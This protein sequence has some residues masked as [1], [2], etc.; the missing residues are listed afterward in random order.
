M[1]TA[2]TTELA[3]E[4][5]GA[6]ALALAAAVAD[7]IR[8]GVAERGEAS[9]VVTGGS[10]P[11]PFYDA[12]SRADLPWDRVRLTLSDERWVAPDDPESNERLVRARLLQGLAAAARLTPLKTPAASPEA[13]LAAVEPAVAAL[14]RPFAAVILGMGEDGHI[15]SL[16]PG[17]ASP[18]ALDAAATALVAAARS[19]A[20]VPRLSLTMTALTDADAVYLLVR[21]EGKR[22]LL[23]DAAAGL[24]PHLPVSALLR[25]A[26]GPVAIYWAP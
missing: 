7:R 16:F 8:T 17:D 2:G 18:A 26:R 19:P 11:G 12:L 23:K 5:A 3:F 14:P 24:R 13:A 22:A 4:G 1:A 20:G 6:Q 10:T 9:L 21:G 15:A 25:Q